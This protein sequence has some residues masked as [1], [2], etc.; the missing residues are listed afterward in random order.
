M[1]EN[2]AKCGS[3]RLRLIV[4]CAIQI[5]LQT[6]RVEAKDKA[7]I[8]VRSP[9]FR[10]LT[11]C[12]QGDARRAA[13]EMERMRYVFAT[14]FSNARLEAGAPLVVY[15]TCDDETLK[16]L[17]PQF[18]G[19]YAGV[20]FHGW[21]KQ[22][23]LIRMDGWAGHGQQIVYHEYTH[24]M[25]WIPVWLDEG[26]AEFYGYTRFEQNRIY[27]GAPTERYRA[28]RSKT[29]ISVEKLISLDQRSPYY[30]D[31]D[32]MQLFYAESWALVHYLMYGP[33]MENGKKLDEFLNLLQQ[34][35]EQKKAFVQTFGDFQKVDKGL[36]AYMLQPA[37]AT[38][39]LKHDPH[40][41]EK[42]FA[43]RT[44]SV[45]ETEAEI[46]A[47]LLW[48]HHLEAAGPHIE[49]ALQEDP[50]LGLAHEDKAFFYFHQGRDADAVNEFKQA[51]ALDGKLYLSLYYL[52]MLSP[53]VTSETATGQRA[54]QDAL[55]DTY[56]LNKQFAPPLV[57]LAILTLRQNDLKDAYDLA[58]KAEEL[59]PS[60]AGYHLLTGKV[61]LRM[62]KGA[63]A[64]DYARYVANRWIAGDHNEA[65]ELWNRIP[66]EQRTAGESLSLD[67]PP[68][69]QTA[70]G[71]VKSATCTEQTGLSDFTIIHEGQ[72]LTFRRKS[73][74]NSS[75]A[76][77][78]WY[79]GDH[80][81][82]CR[83]LEG[84][85]AI[86]HY[87]T[88]TD[89]TYAGD[90]VDIE[91]RDDLGGSLSGASAQNAPS[92]QPQSLH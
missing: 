75:V 24:S 74:F 6:T 78:I 81:T 38:T 61:L 49:Q 68:G 63:E 27:L 41:E 76:D 60:L 20:F 53:L 28:M 31:E 88:A 87:T 29:P 25:H 69:S 48:R 50:K 45:A 89:A 44:M 10:V 51:F 7:W 34:G 22:F 13:G 4:C 43:L 64:A 90:I 33:G 57:Q 77:T 47:F 40:I 85:R 18:K 35:V 42:D 79:G 19:N 56:Q 14:R 91:I 32:K 17:L 8:E 66:P 72:P 23:A 54:F 46:A 12:S 2:P 70:T 1:G 15:V 67:A 58:R 86:I 59:E 3:M 73:A 71:T 83:H 65:V 5:F 80:F 52:T 55:L 26:F 84:K 21:E 37:F 82:L 16:K 30:H 62:G 92:P 9:H 39:I 36:E 11:G